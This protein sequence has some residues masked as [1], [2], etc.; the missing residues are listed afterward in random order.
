MMQQRAARN[1]AVSVTYQEWQGHLCGLLL[2]A[3]LRMKAMR[4]RDHC[5]AAAPPSPPFCSGNNE[6]LLAAETWIHDGLT[7]TCV[8]N[9]NNIRSACIEKKDVPFHDSRGRRCM[10]QRGSW[11]QI[12]VLAWKTHSYF[13]LLRRNLCSEWSLIKLQG[14][15]FFFFFFKQNVDPR[16]DP[17]FKGK[18]KQK[19]NFRGIRLNKTSF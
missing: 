16:R 14:W 3:A 7:F 19:R 1:L 5:T 18:I 15:F 9:S 8:N 4:P 17:I 2:L 6:R 13:K 12:W 11:A 10:R